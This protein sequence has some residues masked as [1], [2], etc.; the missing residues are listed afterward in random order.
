ML[1][2]SLLALCT[3]V[4][5]WSPAADEPGESVT[6]TE[7][8]YEDLDKAIAAGKGKV[9]LVDFWATW[10]APCEFTMPRLKSLAERFKDRGL[11]VVGLTEFYGESNG[12]TL[13][14]DAELS[15]IAAFKKRLRLPYPFAV[16]DSDANNLRYGV[17]ALPTTF[18][19]DRRGVVRYVSVGADDPGDD[20]L[21]AVVKRLL[22]EKQ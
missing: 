18:L 20:T 4:I 2:A 17:R 16:A 10:C 6:A 7:V 11:V 3:L 9:V 13:T 19:I 5:G 22:D 12:K 21:A 15:E 8:K 1:F 14:R